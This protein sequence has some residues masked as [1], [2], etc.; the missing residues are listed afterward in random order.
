MAPPTYHIHDFMLTV[1]K[2]FHYKYIMWELEQ[3]AWWV[4]QRNSSDVR[5]HSRLLFTK[6]MICWINTGCAL[7]VFLLMRF[8]LWVTGWWLLKDHRISVLVRRQH[9]NE[10]PPMIKIKKPKQNMEIAKIITRHI[11]SVTAACSPCCMVVREEFGLQ[12]CALPWC[13]PRTCLPPAQQ[14]SDR[15]VSSLSSGQRIK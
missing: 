6:K 4:W 13:S 1:E 3:G 9:C 14:H 5:E 10:S 8:M 15:C 12:L 7:L 11:W 2:T